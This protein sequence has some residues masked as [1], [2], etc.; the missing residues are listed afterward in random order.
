MQENGM[1]GT[2]LRLQDCGYSSAPGTRLD[3]GDSEINKSAH[4]HKACGLLQKKAR[5]RSASKGRAGGDQKRV[6]EFVWPNAVYS[7]PCKAIHWHL[8]MYKSNLNSA[9]SLTRI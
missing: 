4:V 5:A 8:I 3:C 6:I 9:D 1:T 7:A 2:T